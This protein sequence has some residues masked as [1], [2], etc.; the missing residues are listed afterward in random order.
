MFLIEVCLAAGWQNLGRAGGGSPDKEAFQTL[1]PVCCKFGRDRCAEPQVYLESNVSAAWLWSC[2]PE[3]VSMGPV[4][5]F[6]A[7]LGALQPGEQRARQMLHVAQRAAGGHWK[8]QGVF[9]AVSVLSARQEV[10]RS[11]HAARLQLQEQPAK[12]G[13]EEQ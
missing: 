10:P 5:R 12:R 7:A 6:L 1:V 9:T 11:W 13:E 4:P 2:S 8:G 3:D